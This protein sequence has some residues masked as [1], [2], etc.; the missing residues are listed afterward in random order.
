MI[1]L[2]KLRHKKFQTII[3]FLITL[4]CSLL[5]TS[6]MSIILSLEK[7]FL[8][9][10][11]EC[12]P[13]SV[14]FFLRDQSVEGYEELMAAIEKTKGI[15]KVETLESYSFNEV[16]TKDGEKIE[17]FFELM[18]Y[19]ESVHQNL[20][21][22][23][24]KQLPLEEGECLLPEVVRR[25][26]EL[27][28][29]D[30]I[31]LTVGEEKYEYRIKAF[32]VEPYMSSL[33]TSCAFIVKDIPE[34]LTT[35]KVLMVYG[36]DGTNGTDIV[37]TMRRNNGGHLNA[38]M[39]TIQNM[40]DFNLITGQILGGVLFGGG[41]I[42]LLVSCIII[43]FLVRNT[44]LTDLKTIAIYKT[45][46]YRSKEILGMYMKAYLFVAALGVTLGVVGSKGISYLFLEQ[47]FQS[48]G[49]KS[50]GTLLLPAVITYSI[51]LGVVAVSIYSVMKCTHR[52]SP[53][54]IFANR[55]STLGK[56]KSLKV[57][58]SRVQSFSPL[59]MAMRSMKRERKNTVFII[60][61]A[62]V[63]MYGVNF[64]MASIDTVGSLSEQNYYWLGFD[65]G[66]V[67]FQTN[68]NE[69]FEK[70]YKELEE[71][72][73][74]EC[75]VR[76]NPEIGVEFKWQEGMIDPNVQGY[77]FET[78]EGLDVPVIEGRNPKYQDEVV[79]TSIVAKELGKEIGDYVQI[80]IEDKP[81]SFLLTGIFQSYYGMGRGVR[82][83]GSA[84]DREGAPFVYNTMSIY[85][86]EG[87]DRDVFNESY[88]AIY[89]DGIKINKREEMFKSILDMITEP[90]EKVLTPFMLFI[91]LM[92]F[93][94]IF[95]IVVLR[96]LN[97][98][99]TNSIYKSIGYDS[100]H[101]LKVNMWY[102]GMIAVIA[103]GV[104]L[105]L[106]VVTYP[107]VMSLALMMFG[108]EKYPVFYDLYKLGIV[109]GIVIVLFLMS[110]MFSSRDLF[111]VGIKTLNQE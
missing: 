27:E 5:L 58:K 1:W 92:G 46:G 51:M 81:E 68:D 4:I 97:N 42:I 87:V 88:K 106:F 47:A 32:V 48:I 13:P 29:G 41:I 16:M 105:P 18:P 38:G 83:L 64:A 40:I 70:A 76:Q 44:L 30:T 82:I 75:I 60:L 91:M 80:M 101:L 71:D 59:S 96:N 95:G 43:R 111:K 61:T 37:T 8:E 50:G 19:K 23:S 15:A 110:C 93:I 45:I 11:E 89:G 20:R 34:S 107:K 69:Q 52:I 94:N 26:Y 22:T 73:R 28:V 65:K 31:I 109:N 33:A 72:S 9:L 79:M 35:T 100:R 67:F 66:D 99:K 49:V 17:G 53:V 62:V 12:R 55:Q 98:E 77:F 6:S 85:L 78:L 74:V 3:I 7:P 86:K 24:E 84:W 90:Q 103:S 39:M 21:Y 104:T 56:K 57:G 102:I 63:S 25:Q 36:E 54:A 2:K 10:V 14:R 108:F